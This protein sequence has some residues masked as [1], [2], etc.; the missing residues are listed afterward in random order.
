VATRRRR[1]SGVTSGRG[2]I[3][4]GLNITP[5][6][7]ASLLGPTLGENDSWHV[8]SFRIFLFCS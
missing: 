6:L 8:D 4:V 1:V 5:K 3:F 2:R 7:F